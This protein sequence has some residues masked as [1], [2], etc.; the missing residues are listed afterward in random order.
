M[1]GVEPFPVTVHH[2]VQVDSD[3]GVA[4]E[5]SHIGGGPVVVLVEQPEGGSARLS[6]LQFH[7]QV[8]EWRQVGAGG[9]LPSSEAIL[10][11]D[12]TSSLLIE[13]ALLPYAGV[14]PFFRQ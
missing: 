6:L 1:G 14:E 8:F 9:I 10:S 4:V 12:E 7:H 3:A 2:I 5:V 13:R 11:G